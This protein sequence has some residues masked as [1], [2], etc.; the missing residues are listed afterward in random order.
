MKILLI[1][2]GGREH[3]L[4][5]KLARSPRVSGLWCAPGNAGTARE[6]LAGGGS[7]LN[8]AIG[9]E[10]LPGL[11]VWAKANRPDLTVV[12][13]DNPLALGI[14]D[15]FQS[16]G[17]RIWGPN[18]QAARFESS[19]VFAQEFMLR[20]GIPTARAG[21]F[22]DPGTAKAF[23]SGLGGRCAVK[24]DG[25]ALGEGRAGVRVR[26]RGPPGDRSDAGGTGFRGGQRAYCHS[27]VPRRSGSLPPRAVRRTHRPG[28][29]HIPGPQAGVGRRP[30]AEHRR[31]GDVLAHA[32]SHGCPDG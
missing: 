2:S 9:A 32:L 15:L 6:Q 3:A 14:V 16:E 12:G 8:V 30:R 21:T 4:A 22:S 25:L 26:A 29:S 27:G 17:L 13:P 20:H 1:G 24:A 31:N 23:A 28:L 7:A 5:W 10:D 18:R 11:L 19:K